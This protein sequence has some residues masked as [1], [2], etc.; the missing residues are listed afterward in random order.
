[1]IFDIHVHTNYSSCSELSLDEI[2]HTA[3]MKG[4]DGVCITDHN[5][6]AARNDLEEGLQQD[7]LCILIGMEYDT[8]QGDFLIFGP[9]DDLKT[10][11]DAG[12][13]L[14]T[15]EERGGVAVAAHPYRENRLLDKTV[16]EQGLCRIVES[17]NGR[18]NKEENHRV[19]HLVEP[20]DLIP[21]GGSDAHRLNEL[22]NTA[23]RFLTPIRNRQDL[24]EALRQGLCVPYR[25]AN[26][27]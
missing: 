4:L 27:H 13:L 17:V 2:K 15:V 3:R 9:F 8:P 20:Y 19:K 22:G 5:T 1:M 23:T 24:I 21:C 26:H 14:Q 18:N 25:P 12:R 7:G 6:M 10:G 16:V 11:L